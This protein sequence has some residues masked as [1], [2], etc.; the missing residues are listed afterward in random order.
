M[1]KNKTWVRHEETP[2]Q[3][4]QNRFP[5]QSENKWNRPKNNEQAIQTAQQSDF[6]RSSTSRWNSRNHEHLSQN[7][8]S[9]STNPF[10]ATDAPFQK[11][12]NKIQSISD[13][14]PFQKLIGGTSASNNIF[15]PPIH[16]SPFSTSTSRTPGAAGT[17]SRDPYYSTT[18]TSSTSSL[19][20]PLQTRENNHLR[21]NDGNQSRTLKVNATLLQAGMGADL[22]PLSTS[23]H[24]W[25]HNHTAAP[26]VDMMDDNSNDENA[27][28]PPPPLSLSTPRPSSSPIVDCTPGATVHLSSSFLNDF[29][30]EG[31]LTCATGKE[32]MFDDG[33]EEKFDVHFDVGPFADLNVNFALTDLQDL[34]QD[35][36]F[37]TGYIPDLILF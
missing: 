9:R 27:L 15:R 19:Y 16:S 28:P 30:G 34:G 6:F 10:Q 29:K 25:P 32:G 35:Q 3:N 24:I 7:R 13:H 20:P 17:P 36:P 4:F 8:S 1:E 5:S 31:T 11:Q 12:D 37:L 18:P 23:T 26:D 2:S 21:H 22:Y 33:P 14:N